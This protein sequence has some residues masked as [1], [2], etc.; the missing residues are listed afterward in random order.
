MILSTIIACFSIIFGNP[1]IYDYSFKTLE[2]KDVKMSDFKGKK[3]LIVNTA[4]KCGFTKQYKDLQELYSLYGKDLVIIGFP[5]N[6]FGNQ[7]PGTNGDIQEFCEQNYGVEFLMA[8][9]V[10]VKGDQI[11]PLFKYLIAQKNP[12]FEGE[13][14][15]NFEKFLI[16]ENGKLIHR[17][18]SAVNPMADEI[19]NWVKK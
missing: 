13:I 6:N 17:Y 16:D 10:E 11:D 12:D 7:E 3:I 4:S 1:S 18:R 14:K 5:A 19:V 15:W 9:K 8:E 2:G